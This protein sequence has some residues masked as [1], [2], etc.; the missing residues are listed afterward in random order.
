MSLGT[1]L[2]IASTNQKIDWDNGPKLF[3]KGNLSEE[4]A[5]KLNEV[6]FSCEYDDKELD[7]SFIS[8]LIALNERANNL[9]A[10]LIVYV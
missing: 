3:K 6:G 2:Y 4:R 7:A 5:T 10:L 8:L 9:H 1:V